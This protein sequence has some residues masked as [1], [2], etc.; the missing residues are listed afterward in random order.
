MR[1]YLT[2]LILL[3]L[4]SCSSVNEKNKN[5]LVGDIK[6]DGSS[7]VYPVTEA[8]AEEFRLIQPNVRVTVGVSGTGGGFKKFA[9]G[10]TNIS[11]ASRPI[12]NKE[13]LLCKENN[14]SYIGLSVAYD[15]LAVIVNP[16][17]DWVDYF[18]VEEL[19]KIWHPD[20]Q[21]SILKWSQIREGWPNEEIHLFGPGTASGTYDYFSEVICGKKVGTRGDYTASEVDHVLVQGVAT[22][23]YGLG[24]FGL[25]YYEEN[26]D[27][28]RVVG[29]DNGSGAIIP[30]KETVSNGSYN[31]LSRPIF[32]Y[33][34]NSS[35][36]RKEVEAFV[37]FYLKNAGDLVSDVG[38]IP[39]T[40]NEYELELNKFMEYIK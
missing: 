14:I 17:N 10:E 37:T 16:Q 28:L 5:L 31:P 18:T 15:G 38:Y 35:K 2:S 23:K 13:A 32:I 36:E 33:A 11:N 1:I 12:K 19:N 24:F 7:T 30:S 4:F 34:N 39:L 26:K 25:A 21:N 8:I 6:I 22:D 20:A 9:R 3:T 27:K 40:K 29:V